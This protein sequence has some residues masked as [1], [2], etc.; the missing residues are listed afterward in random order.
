MFSVIAA[1]FELTLQSSMNARP[2]WGTKSNERTEGMFSIIAAVSGVL[3][4]RL[5]YLTQYL[6]NMFSFITAVSE[7]RENV[8]KS[9]SFPTRYLRYM[10]SVIAA[11]L[12]LTL[13]SSMNARAN[14][15]K[16]ANERT[17]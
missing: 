15:D 7:L 11:G 17:E 13:Q 5:L 1:G 9:L 6:G 16:K 4:K 10:F 3:G 2:N 8:R 14:W 12:Y